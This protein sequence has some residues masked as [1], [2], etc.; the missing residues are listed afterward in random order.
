MVLCH[1]GNMLVVLSLFGTQVHAIIAKTGY[2]HGGPNSYKINKNAGGHFNY[3]HGQ[4]SF[5]VLAKSR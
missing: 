3:Y 5:V 4:G 1:F 2:V